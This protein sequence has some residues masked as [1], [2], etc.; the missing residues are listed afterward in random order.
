MRVLSQIKPALVFLLLVS[1]PAAASPLAES[2]L[3][4]SPVDDIITQYPE[5]MSQGVREGLMQ[6][7]RVEPFVANTI[8][9]VV[10]SAFSVAEIRGQVVDDLDQGLSDQQLESV[11][12]WYETPLARKISAAE[13][14]ASKPAVWDQVEAEAEALQSKYEGSERS[15]LFARFDAAAGATESAVDTTVAVQL[16][17]AAAMAAVNGASGPTVEQLKQTIETQ[18]GALREM[19]AQQVYVGYLY[20]YQS[21][22]TPELKDY[23][24]F[25]ESDAG[26][27]FADVVSNSI[28]RSITEPV[29]AVGSQLVRLFSPG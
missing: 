13:V 29:E 3:R 23:I 25:L 1:G 6:S 26:S 24:G 28:Q 27:A 14:A 11:L 18:R 8:S 10:T 15:D 7:G 20:T 12:A 17:L 21:L 22:S 5:M 4:T 16:G 9:R 19:V 2:V